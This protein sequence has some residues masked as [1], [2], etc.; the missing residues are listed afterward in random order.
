MKNTKKLI[1]QMELTL[2]EVI[3]FLDSKGYANTKVRESVDKILNHSDD[4]K[5]KCEKEIESVQIKNCLND[6]NNKR[7]DYVCTTT[8]FVRNIIEMK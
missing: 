7:K 8:E 3:Q 4:L 6:L 5:E 1:I 2:V